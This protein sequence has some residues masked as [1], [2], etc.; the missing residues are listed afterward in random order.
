MADIIERKRI[1]LVIE[2]FDQSGQRVSLR[3][4]D[5]MKDFVKGVAP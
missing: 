1:E 5:A 2:V 4:V 3:S